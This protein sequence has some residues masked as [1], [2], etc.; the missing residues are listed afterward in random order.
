MGPAVFVWQLEPFNTEEVI[1]SGAD[2]ANFPADVQPVPVETFAEFEGLD[3]QANTGQLIIALR[4]AYDFVEKRIRQN[5]ITRRMKSVY[6]IE[7][8]LSQLDPLQRLQVRVPGIQARDIAIKYGDEVIPIA[9]TVDQFQQSNGSCNLYFPIQA[10]GDIDG[11]FLTVER[12]V[13]LTET[14]YETGYGGPNLLSAVQ[15]L[16]KAN[17]ENTAT[18]DLFKSIL[19]MLNQYTFG[20]VV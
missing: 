4:S 12:T 7:S 13:G 19:W 3:I 17:Y 18:S 6:I 11:R 8:G 2:K 5:V 1:L 15:I 9:N 16:A 20:E 14:M 10:L